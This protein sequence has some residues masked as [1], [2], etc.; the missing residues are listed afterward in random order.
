M[1]TNFKPIDVKQFQ[2]SGHPPRSLLSFWSIVGLAICFAS[3]L[4]T[5]FII[6]FLLRFITL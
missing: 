5:G 2:L 1:K 3:T 6:F 4:F